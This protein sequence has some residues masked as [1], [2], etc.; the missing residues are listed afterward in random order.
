MRVVDALDDTSWRD[1]IAG[2]SNSSIFHTPEMFEVF[3]RAEGFDP[4]IWAVVDGDNCP[5]ALLLPV[6]LTLFGGLLKLITRRTVVYGS[7]LWDPTAAGLEALTLLLKTYVQESQGK[8][9]FTE[10]RNLTD[11]SSVQP[12]LNG[13]GFSFED[14]LNFLIDLK[15]SPEELFQSIGP[16]TRKGIRRALSRGDVA[17]QDVTEASQLGAW[18]EVL[19]KTYRNAHVPLAGRS[20]FEAAF[21]ILVPKSMIRFSQ[22]RIDSAITA[23]SADLLYKDQI[24]GW[25]GGMDR[26]YGPSRSNEVLTWTILAWGAEHG[27]RVYDFGGAGKP[28][29]PYG[30]RDFKAKFNGA[31]VNYGRNTHIGSRLLYEILNVG[32]EV[33]RKVI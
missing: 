9:L 11:L 6:Q 17:I 19:D 16:R 4:A 13:Q 14:H 33:Y 28:G 1:F 31:L 25:Y 23:T 32:Y 26:A 12:I 29:R 18:Y 3:R 20:L 8:T 10:L 30:P 27:F 24:Y 22:A 2:H 21:D 7:V 15:R 5:L